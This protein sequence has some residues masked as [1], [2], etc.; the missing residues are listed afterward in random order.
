MAK[1]K[2][3]TVECANWAQV[4]LLAK[5]MRAFQVISISSPFVAEHGDTIQVGIELPSALRIPIFC[6]VLQA[7]PQKPDRSIF[8][9]RLAL[10]PNRKSI[11]EKLETEVAMLHGGSEQLSTNSSGSGTKRVVNKE[12]VPKQQ[13][14]SANLDNTDD[15]SDENTT[16]EDTKPGK[17]P[18]TSSHLSEE[19]LAGLTQRIP[20]MNFTLQDYPPLPSS[21]GDVDK[22]D[23]S[24]RTTVRMPSDDNLPS[25]YVDEY[26]RPTQHNERIP[27]L[28]KSVAL[29]LR[30]T[31]THLKTQTPQQVFGVGDD[32]T[33]SL[34][35]AAFEEKVLVYHPNSFSQYSSQTI[36]QLSQEIVAVLEQKRVSLLE[37]VAS[38]PIPPAEEE[39]TSTSESTISDLAADYIQ[40]GAL[41]EATSFVR[42]QYKSIGGPILRGLLHVCYGYLAI[43]HKEV[44]MAISQLEAALV[45]DPKCALAH[46]GL[47]KL[48]SEPACDEVVCQLF[49]VRSLREEQTRLA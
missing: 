43:K 6:R 48:L 45:H 38:V 27:V 20:R 3:I 25:H 16:H 13:Q 8:T 18:D 34:V 46:E 17:K 10:G 32:T 22:L 42:N 24:L 29:E 1:K 11:A 23:P 9:L 37:E 19:S 33:A 12:V 5:R 41:L 49:T 4:T 47:S 30:N 14:T 44:D 26:S 36:T 2:R 21:A 40:R 35:N 28:E 39:F 15:G 31:L 7:A